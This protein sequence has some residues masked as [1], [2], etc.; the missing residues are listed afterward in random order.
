MGDDPVAGVVMWFLSVA[1]LAVVVPVAAAGGAIVVAGRALVWLGR[2]GQDLIQGP[3]VARELQRVSRERN[4]AI[5]DIVTLRNEGE[6][7]LRSVAD[8]RV[9]DATAE[10]WGDD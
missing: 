9:A 6:R 1:A 8:G 3:P 7:R 4:D 5:R 2:R 10:E